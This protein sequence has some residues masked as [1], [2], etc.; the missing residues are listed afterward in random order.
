MKKITFLFLAF[1][2]LGTMTST[3]LAAKTIV[4]DDG[5]SLTCDQTFAPRTLRYSY[6]YGFHDDF[7]NP[8]TSTTYYINGFTINYKNGNYLN[9]GKPFKLTDALK[10][11]L[12]AVAPNQT[13]RIL[14]TGG[15]DWR[16]ASHPA[17]RTTG[18]GYDFMIGYETKYDTSN[19]YPDASDDKSHIGCQ[20]YQ[21]S[22]CGDGMIDAAYET[23]D[24]GASNGLPGKCNIACEQINPPESNTCNQTFAPVV[25]RYW[26]KYNFG[27]TYH[28]ID[29]F[30]HRLRS[31]GIEFI[32]K[33]DYNL[34][35]VVPDFNWTQA[36]KST[37]FIIGANTN[38]TKIIESTNE[39]EIKSTPLKRGPDNLIIKYRTNT[40]NVATGSNI[41]SHL[42]CQ[43]Y[44]ISWCGDGVRDTQFGEPCDP[45]A[46]P[47]KSNGTCRVS[48]TD[49]SKCEI[50]TNP[51]TPTKTG[52]VSIKR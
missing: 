15:D 16:V 21:V 43:P 35:P 42:A 44:E 51:P 45:M 46:E 36:I 9:M 19:N 7:R 6:Y 17:T 31:F 38:N 2:A 14:E 3:T 4:F 23:C 13:M 26:Q 8:N 22:W 50:V 24:D 28:N 39:Y 33:Y 11:S 47:W 18:S 37:D 40:E 49:G 32:E 5:K 30:N 52:S 25:L 20:P 29:N 41:I 1:I 10:S 27:H 48:L 12:H 34:S